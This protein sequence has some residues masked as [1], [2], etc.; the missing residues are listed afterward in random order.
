MHQIINDKNPGNNSLTY[1]MGKENSVLK[2][3]TLA[4]IGGLAGCI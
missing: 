3:N 4:R 2:Y 1:A